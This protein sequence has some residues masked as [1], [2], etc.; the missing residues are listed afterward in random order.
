MTRR[1]YYDRVWKGIEKVEAFG[2]IPIKINVVLIRGVNDDEIL[3]FAR[4]HVLVIHYKVY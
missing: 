3:N 4:L 2:D 1:N